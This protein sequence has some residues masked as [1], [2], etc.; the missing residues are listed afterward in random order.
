L[1]VF[2]LILGD[3]NKG[4][5][6]LYY[7]NKMF[8]VFAGIA[9]TYTLLIEIIFIGF[10]WIPSR[11]EFVE[12]VETTARS[13]SEYTDSR[14]KSPLETA[15]VLNASEYT[16]KYLS[17]TLSDYERLRYIKFIQGIHGLTATQKFGLA[18]TKYDDNY[19]IM[20]NQTGGMQYFRSIFRLSESQ[21]ESVI[22]YFK[23][24]PRVLSQFFTAD[25]SGTTTTY[26]IARQE[27]FGKSAPIY[28]FTAYHES[29]L[30]DL[31]ALSS[32]TLALFFNNK[33]VASSG[34]LEP[35]IVKNLADN[36]FLETD[37]IK[38]DTSSSV[39]GYRY[40]Y[41]TEPQAILTP[42][43]IMIMACGLVAMTVS[44]WL[45]AIVTRKMYTPIEGVLKSTGETF[46]S[47]D[48][49][50]HIKSTIQSLYTNMETMSQS[51]AQFKISAENRFLHELLTGLLPQE[52]IHQKLQR[53]PK[54]EI[55]GPFVVILIQY[56]ET[57]QFTG[58]FMHGM[59]YNAKQQLNTALESLFTGS[60]MFRIIDLNFETQ[61]IIVQMNEQRQ[62]QEKL[63]NSIISMEPET[64]L[65][66]TAII[67]TTCESLSTISVSYRKAV[68]T[69]GMQY[70]NG[71][72]VKVTHADDVKLS[73]KNSVYYPLHLE[74]TLINAV[75]HRKPAIWQ[76]SLEEIILTNRQER[77]NS[78]EPLSLMLEVTVNRIIDGSEIDLSNLLESENSE[79]IRFRTC[80]S[81]DE[82][83]QKA[84]DLFSRLEVWFAKEQEK[85][86]SGLADTM[87][88][89]IHAN[90]Q[91]N[92]SLFDLADY[93]NLS[94]NYV[95][96]LFKNAVGRNF[97]DYVG[98]YRFHQACAIIQSNPDLR[99][100]DVADM[101]GCNTEILIRLFTRYA[102][103]LP[104]D[105]QQ[106][107][108][109]NEKADE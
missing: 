80:R 89:Y 73:N 100:K 33:L 102:G 70:Y 64:G 10:Y 92:I 22:H 56:N 79:V 46:T 50:A 35:D 101:V 71:K 103:M 15:L 27:W 53:F 2:S 42:T 18:V 83:H 55:E 107:W 72:H 51:L 59:T 8:R 41:L 98:E 26:M 85:A 36:N 81:F 52:Q 97:K 109:K 40:V 37:Y 47:G 48:E 4:G 95:S 62:L 94:R 34:L 63:R 31:N 82:L 60:R 43:L 12:S 9:I 74:Q 75:I 93:L 30:F 38:Y 19:V 66:I 13:L 84:S 87:L 77:G 78:L 76:S 58:E 57:G 68:K 6:G 17:N 39:P 65:E 54:L 32:G 28:T 106:Q 61:A 91:N 11:Q 5:L 3:I 104:S 7:Y 90:Y 23:D 49:F 108:Q 67:G 99:L 14:L 69:A 1:Y 24:N 45:M 105:Y 86:N 88:S 29:Q 96:S 44:I 20:N 16:S 21:L 25:L